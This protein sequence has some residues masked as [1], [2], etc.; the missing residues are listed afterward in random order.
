MATKTKTIVAGNP[1]I[2]DVAVGSLI[3]KE[4]A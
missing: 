3:S 2:S 1:Q 4:A